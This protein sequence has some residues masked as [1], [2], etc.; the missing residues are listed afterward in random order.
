MGNG[1]SRHSSSA[2]PMFFE[3]GLVVVLP[4]IFSVAHKLEIKGT[5]KGSPMCLLVFR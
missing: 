1:A 2:F 4:L 3:V 5:T